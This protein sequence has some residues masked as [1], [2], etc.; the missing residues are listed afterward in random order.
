MSTLFFTQLWRSH[1][2]PYQRV[3]WFLCEAIE[4]EQRLNLQA[5]LESAT[6]LSGW[7]LPVRRSDAA[8]PRGAPR[9][10]DTPT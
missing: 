4:R 1:M 2:E 8:R 10:I 9:H 7:F 6:C 3:A 5:M